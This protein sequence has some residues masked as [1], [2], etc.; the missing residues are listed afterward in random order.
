[1]DKLKEKKVLFTVG[2]GFVNAIQKEEFDL[3]EFCNVE[4]IE[5]K[6]E[7]QELLEEEWEHWSNEHIDGSWE[8]DGDDV[9]F[10]LSIGFIGAERE[11]VMQLDELYD[12]DDYETEEELDELLS[13]VWKDWI[14]NYIDGSWKLVSK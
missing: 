8:V 7:L 1:M 10:T 3:E 5:T 13:E 4:D 14:G 11:D 9:T 12:P 2:I 6:E